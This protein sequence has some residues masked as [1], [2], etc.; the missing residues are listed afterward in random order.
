MIFRYTA[1]INGYF[2]RIEAQSLK[3]AIT[4]CQKLEADTGLLPLPSEIEH[5]KLEEVSN[6]EVGK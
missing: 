4:I 2:W 1:V 6:A 5:F 3:E